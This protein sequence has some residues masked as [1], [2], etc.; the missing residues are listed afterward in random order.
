MTTKP[1]KPIIVSETKSGQTRVSISEFKGKNYLDV[2]NYYKD[3]DGNFKP[4]PKGCSVPIENTRK[5]GIAI[6]KLYL[7]AVDAGLIEE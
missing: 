4:T 2:R 6:K 3:S 1:I 7:A 5:L